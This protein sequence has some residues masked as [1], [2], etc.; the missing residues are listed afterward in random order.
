MMWLVGAL[1]IAAFVFLAL[2]RLWPTDPTKASW[3]AG[4]IVF[5]STIHRAVTEPDAQ[6]TKV[7]LVVSA[8]VFLVLIGRLIRT[9]RA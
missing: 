7:M 1:V 8:V 4:A 5:A 6:W 9:R 3:L 2:M